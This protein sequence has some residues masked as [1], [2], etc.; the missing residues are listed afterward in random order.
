MLR[1]LAVGAE[2]RILVNVHAEDAPLID[3]LTAEQRRRGNTDVRYLPLSRPPVAEAIASH[4]VATYAAHLGCPVYFVHVSSAAALDVLERVR[5]QGAEIYIET[6]P[7]YLFLDGTR[8]ELPEREGNRYVCLPP[9]RSMSD[10]EALWDGLQR[11]AVQTYATDHSPWMA[12]QKLD[13]AREFWRI[14]PGFANLQTSIPMLFSEGVVKDR[15]TLRQFVELTST[16]PAKLF[17]LYPRKGTIAVG[18][19]ADLLVLD[20]KQSFR[21]SAGM[22]QSRS[23]YEPFEDMEGQGQA[24]YVLSRGDVIVEGNNILSRPGRGRFLARKRIARGAL[25]SSVSA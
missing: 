11:G 4:R 24:R 15:I 10:R 18:S 19:D 7:A 25:T 14:P 21:L 3:Y 23:D 1:V 12:A 16:N 20:P 8:Y 6:R 5:A 13:P 17:G 2:N 9:L 22:M